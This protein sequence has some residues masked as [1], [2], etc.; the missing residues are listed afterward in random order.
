MQKSLSGQKYEDLISVV[1]GQYDRLPVRPGSGADADRRGDR[2]KGG[3]KRLGR[4]P[5]APALGKR[6][7]EALA[8]PGPVCASSPLASILGQCSGSAALSSDQG[9]SPPCRRL[10]HCRYGL[11]PALPTIY[12]TGPLILN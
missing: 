10:L 6:I 12:V 3:G 7:C 8:T 9:S 4:P 5:I 1:R 11:L 2:V